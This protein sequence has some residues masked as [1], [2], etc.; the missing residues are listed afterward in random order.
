M[1]PKASGLLAFADEETE[2]R[3]SGR[4][5]PEEPAPRWDGEW[6]QRVGSGTEEPLC[7]STGPQC[8]AAQGGPL[9]SAPFCP[10]QWALSAGN[11]SS[12]VEGKPAGVEGAW[13][14][15]VGT[16]AHRA[17]IPQAS[18]EAWKGWHEGCVQ[19]D[20]K[21]GKV[22]KLADALELRQSWSHIET[23]RLREV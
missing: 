23:Q 2:A 14:G 20:V 21:L 12:E 3:D 13:G 8:A 4:T 1:S 11:S 18:A 17:L 10:Q 22:G 16:Q 5:H 15:V 6:G 7:S 19:P 9:I